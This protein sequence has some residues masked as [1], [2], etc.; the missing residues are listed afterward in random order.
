M[1]KRALSEGGIF[2]T[3]LPKW[4]MLDLRKIARKF[5]EISIWNGSTLKMRNLNNFKALQPLSA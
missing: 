4:L 2:S 1:A 5:N 3:P